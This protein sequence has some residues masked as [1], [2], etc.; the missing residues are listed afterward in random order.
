MAA[1]PDCEGA[2]Q[3]GL[4]GVQLRCGVSVV[5]CLLPLS[6]AFWAAAELHTVLTST[7]GWLTGVGACLTIPPTAA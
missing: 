3:E 5:V 4:C 6:L 2:A 7:G 1:P